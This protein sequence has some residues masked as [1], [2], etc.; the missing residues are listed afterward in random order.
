MN[1]QKTQK[2]AQHLVEAIR[3]ANSSDAAYQHML[4]TI[5]DDI[6]A[7]FRGE[8]VCASRVSE[9]VRKWS[10]SNG[11]AYRP[12]WPQNEYRTPDKLESD[13]IQHAVQV[14]ESEILFLGGCADGQ[15]RLTDGLAVIR[16]P[17]YN[18]DGTITEVYYRREI[19]QC[20][21]ATFAVMVEKSRSMVWAMQTL[22]EG[23]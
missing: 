17:Q 19:I 9:F 18:N 3:K 14:M 16:M 7:E 6:D 15:R 4:D 8:T 21:D 10:P 2:Q 12:A 23:Y 5:A 13:N 22:L 1:N 11:Q 20:E